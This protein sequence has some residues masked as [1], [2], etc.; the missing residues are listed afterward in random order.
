ML[1]FRVH[2]KVQCP[3]STSVPGRF[4]VQR[5][6]AVIFFEGPR[7]SSRNL[8]KKQRPIKVCMSFWSTILAWLWEVSVHE[9]H[10]A[11]SLSVLL[12]ISSEEKWWNF[13]NG[14]LLWIKPKIHLKRWPSPSHS[15]AYPKLNVTTNLLHHM[16]R[17]SKRERSVFFVSGKFRRCCMQPAEKT[18][19]TKTT[20]TVYWMREDGLIKYTHATCIPCEY[21][22]TC[23]FLGLGLLMATEIP[24]SRFIW[25]ALKTEC[26]INCPI[27]AIENVVRL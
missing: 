7:K 11:V 21:T 15:T 6:H 14:N 10:S 26:C 16:V 20:H 4:C 22:R 2:T 23:L 18:A 24:A 5:P 1:R 27:K 25:V 19:S 9:I 3:T 8:G 17:Y 13:A 12:D